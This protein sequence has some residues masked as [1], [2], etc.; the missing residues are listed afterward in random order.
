MVEGSR[1]QPQLLRRV[2]EMLGLRRLRSDR[3]LAGLVED[4]L[5]LDAIGGLRRAGLTDDEI[6]RL[7]VPRRTLTHRRTRSEALSRDESDRAVRV[8]RIAALAEHVFGDAQR[9]WRWLRAPK[10]QFG[11]RSPLELTLTEAGARVVEEL[12]YRVDDGMGA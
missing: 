10:R 6:Y 2:R 8:A 9:G 4:R 1:S 5:A 3:D 11:G 7:I 12:L